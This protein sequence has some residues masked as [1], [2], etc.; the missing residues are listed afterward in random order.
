M[1]RKTKELQTLWWEWLSASEKLQRMLHEQTAALTLRDV[2]RFER[3][4]PEL[5]STMEQIRS[6]D[7]L[8]AATARELAGE[9]G[10]QPNL[11]SVVAALEKAEAQQVQQLANRIVVASQTIEKVIAK[12]RRLI[13]N[14]LEYVNGTLALVARAAAEPKTPYQA[15]RREACVVLNEVA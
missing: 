9:L 5:D 2:A 10:C 13:S 8:A 12:N 3:L 14:E 7:D 1:S 15:K 4:Q 6:I 11:R